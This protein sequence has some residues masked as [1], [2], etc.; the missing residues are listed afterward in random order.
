MYRLVNAQ[1]LRSI[2]PK[3]EDLQPEGSNATLHSPLDCAFGLPVALDL[4]QL[5]RKLSTKESV[6]R[7][8]S[9]WSQ[10]LP[11]GD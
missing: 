1:K 7:K 10:K 6:A 8:E 9:T 5:H 11:T 2:S 4:C 3:D